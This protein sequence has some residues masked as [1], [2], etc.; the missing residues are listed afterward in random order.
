MFCLSNFLTRFVLFF[1]ILSIA[2]CPQCVLSNPS[3][4]YQP[5][6]ISEENF[7]NGCL[8]T[9][10]QVLDL[11][12]IIE[13]DDFMEIYSP[14]D[15]EKINQ[16]LVYL[17]KAGVIE[18]DP[19]EEEVLKD[20]EE[21]LR[22]ASNICEN[23]VYSN[24]PY[25]F[26]IVPAI[27]YGQIE[28]SVCK[29][30]GKKL[31]SSFLP[32]DKHRYYQSKKFVAKNRKPILIGEA[33]LATT[34][35][36]AAVGP[37]VIA[38]A[39]A[40]AAPALVPEKEASNDSSQNEQCNT[41]DIIADRVETIKE[42]VKESDNFQKNVSMNRYE[43]LSFGEKV[44]SVG[45]DVAHQILDEIGSFT[46]QGAEMQDGIKTI[47]KKFLPDTVSSS[48]AA[49][50]QSNAEEWQKKIA[51]GHEKIDGVFSTDQAWKYT[52]EGKESK[53]EMTNAVIPFPGKSVLSPV[54]NKVGR[55]AGTQAA[56]TCG[57]K[58]GDS[59]INRTKSGNVPKWSTVR[60]RY[61]KNEALAQKINPT[62]SYSEE[63]LK[64]MEK[65]LAP[66]RKVNGQVESMELHH[67][68]AQKDG[69]LFDF[70]EVWPD[71]HAKLDPNRILGG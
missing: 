40:A 65:G 46:I 41:R 6:E 21:L 10:D 49:S 51:A 42:E 38:Y 60:K 57:W 23:C 35:V 31:L 8:L 24:N 39:C 63:N 11:L 20:C 53:M 56:D 34:A 22:G 62:K 29:N 66:Q 12:D 19:E 43:E 7:P 9:Y 33:V 55:I 15:L 36:V 58:P 70:V 61:W 71:Q 26:S 25:A 16:F 32:I 5:C 14:E 54:K 48:N 1:T 3:F 64:R 27:S 47:G 50:P 44:R 52:P 17:A 69:G 67:D 18:D 68:P 2:I 37:S 4:P 13:S 59:I 30:F 45:S 28:I